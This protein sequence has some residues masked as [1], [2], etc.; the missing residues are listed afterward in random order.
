MN[1]SL[2]KYTAFDSALYYITFK[3]RSQNEIEQKLKDKG[4]SADEIDEAVAKLLEYNYINDSRY[5]NLYIKS[6][7]DKKGMS[8]ITNE[9]IGKGINKDIISLE[10]EKFEFQEDK[11][12][13][14]EIKRKYGIGKFD[15]KMKA[16][17]YG[18]FAR[19]GFKYND[20]SKA[21]TH[22]NDY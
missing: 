9:L 1:N 8:R 7:I 12:I 17:I 3:E 16:K 18:Y 13:A 19:R 11:A 6:N 22:I 5:A 15:D 2:K 10:L 20:I 14:T 21:L 4:Y